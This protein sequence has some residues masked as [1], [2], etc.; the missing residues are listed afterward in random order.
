MQRCRAFFGV[1]MRRCLAFLCAL[2]LA[3]PAFAQ[4][5]ASE[6]AW[7]T[8]S[9]TIIVPYPAGSAT[10]IIAR[11]VSHGLSPRLG[12]PIVVEN[13]PGADATIGTRAVAKAAPDGYTLAF[14]T[15]SAYVSAPILYA[16]LGYDPVKDFAPVSLAGRTPYLFAVYPG[17]GVKTVL[18]LVALARSKP[19]ELN[20][21]SVGEGSIAHVGMLIFANKMGIALTHIPYKS[22]AQSIVDLSTGIIH[23]Q[24]A[25]IPPTVP[26]YQ[27]GKVQVLA[28][29][30]TQRVALMPDV[31]TMAE[32]GVPGYEATFWLA[33]FAPAGAPATIVA[34]LNRELA[35]VLKAED[36]KKAFA[37]QGVEPEHST[38]EE[39]AALLRHDID[40]F[41]GVAVRAGIKPQ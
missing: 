24:L 9:V 2:L 1:L 29:A 35:E 25:S 15:P 6:T 32:A 3:E 28:V 34:R 41:R 23:L 26:F 22:T 18:D 19:G 30:G 13:R 17:L 4:R 39:L 11:I 10:D 33:M 37:P 31:P 12:Q 8:R 27:A 5:P 40:D 36:L 16:N 20:F 38:P 21:S 7:P 14:G